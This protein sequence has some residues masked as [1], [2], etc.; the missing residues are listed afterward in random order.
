MAPDNEQFFNAEELQVVDLQVAGLHL[1]IGNNK[2]KIAIRLPTCHKKFIQPVELPQALLLQKKNELHKSFGSVLNITI[3][4]QS[5]FPPPQEVSPVYRSTSWELWQLEK[6]CYLLTSPVHFPDRKLIFDNRFTL[7]SVIDN[8]STKYKDGCYP[9]EYLDIR[10]FSIW[11]ASFG[12]L[13]LHASG[14][15]MDGRGYAFLGTSGAGK[16]TLA[17]ELQKN[18]AVTVLGEDQV[19]LR[20]I[21][22][23]FW[24]FGTPWHMTPSMCSPKGVKLKKLFFLNRYEKTGLKQLSPIVG[25]AQ[26]LQTAFIPYHFSEDVPLILDRL[27]LLSEKVPFYSLS[28][29]LGTDPLPYISG[30]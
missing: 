18:P 5:P 9:L 20:Y 17:A 11:L 13:I 15:E 6:D 19:I 8:F 14:V 29:K 7:G 1:R 4:D 27:S 3:I 21:D 22:G 16:S 25:M 24:I 12:D 28:Y 23:A 30:K 10:L 2:A 26:I